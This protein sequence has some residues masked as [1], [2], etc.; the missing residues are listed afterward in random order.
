METIANILT[1]ISL[2]T[3][4]ISMIFVCITTVIL[5]YLIFSEVSKERKI[6][7]LLAKLY[8]SNLHH[9]FIVKE[10]FHRTFVRE[11]ETVDELLKYADHHSFFKIL[12]SYRDEEFVKGVE[13]LL[14]E[15]GK[16][17]NRWRVFVYQMLV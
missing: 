3:L 16:N 4:S 2:V 6:V 8:L 15:K 12:H 13:K 7:K 10:D 11:K 17:E 9:S 1:N 14:E 5:I